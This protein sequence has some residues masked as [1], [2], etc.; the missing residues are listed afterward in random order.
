MKW[1]AVTL[2]VVVLFLYPRLASA[3]CEPIH[4]GITGWMVGAQP[5]GGGPGGGI[6]LEPTFLADYISEV[7]LNNKVR[8]KDADMA[9]DLG[10]YEQFEIHVSQIWFRETENGTM[11]AGLL[12][13]VYEWEGINFRA[14]TPPRFLEPCGSARLIHSKAWLVN[15]EDTDSYLTA[16]NYYFNNRNAFPQELV[17]ALSPLGIAIFGTLLLACGAIVMRARRKRSY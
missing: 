3:E 1:L 14:G 5:P 12:V 10:L 8:I 2:G 4:F 15:S 13:N 17:P 11:E 16:A 9:K 6:S 7:F